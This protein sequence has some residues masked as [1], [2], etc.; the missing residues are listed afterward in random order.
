MAVDLG[1]KEAGGGEARRV[2]CA[3]FY[4]KLDVSRELAFENREKSS[5]PFASH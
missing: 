3:G 2:N 4:G 5:T 1:S